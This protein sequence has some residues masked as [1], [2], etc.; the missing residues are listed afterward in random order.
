MKRTKAEQIFSFF[1]Y[2]FL[3]L[4]S[5]VCLLP[6]LTLL[7]KSFSSEAA[8]VSKAV[9][10]WPVGFHT[11]AYTTLMKSSYFQVAFRNSALVTVAGTL[12]HVFFTVCVGYVCSKE[13][14]MPFARAITRMYVCTMLFSGGTIP[15][16]I[17]VKAAGLMNNL[18]AMILPG[19][20][21]TFNMILVR[22][23]FYTVPDSLEE[24][25]KLDGASNLQV[26]FR[27]ML[28]MAIPSVATVAIFV[29]VGL[30]NNYMQ[31]LMYLTRGEVRMLSVYLKDIVTAA[32]MKSVENPDLF[33]RVASESF[34]AA[35]IFVSTLPILVVYPF[36]QKYFIVGISL[37][38]IKE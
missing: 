22:N 36:L 20:V 4:L 25:G 8:V 10:F 6:Y 26:F 14:R 2:S 16:F 13:G 15:T 23:Y 37:G 38:A 17:V 24:S 27:I 28:P 31:P 19:M 5:L 33:D 12:V 18:L 30:W 11:K 9:T 35:A 21:T 34:R 7:A 32:D 29:A 1:N 3:L